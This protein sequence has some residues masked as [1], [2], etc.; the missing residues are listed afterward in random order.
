METAPK[1]RVLLVDDQRIFAENLNTFLSNYADDIV[2]TGIA[3]NGMEALERTETDKPDI[4]L[5]DIHMPVMNGVE[6]TAAIKKLNPKIRI[7]VLSTYDE[8]EYVRSA[9]SNGA[10]GYLLKDISPTELIASIRALSN[11][12]LQISPQIAQKLIS[13]LYTTEDEKPAGETFEWYKTLSKREREI[14]AL[15]ATGFDN[16]EIAETLFLAEQTVRNHVSLIYS[17]LQ[18]K[19]RFEIIKLANKIRIS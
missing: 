7:L 3:G 15:I 12:V 2:V 13:R 6:A 8:D 18:V 1:I 11:G 17:K 19:D 9:L 14:F 4:I 16:D 5:M 10:S